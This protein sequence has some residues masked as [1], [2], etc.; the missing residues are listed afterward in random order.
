MMEARIER[1]RE[2]ATAI[3]VAHHTPEKI[4]ELYPHPLP[5]KKVK[6]WGVTNGGS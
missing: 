2:D 3:A 1:R 4:S 6:W 5:P